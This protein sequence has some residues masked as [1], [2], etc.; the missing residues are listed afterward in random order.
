MAFNWEATET[1]WFVD[2]KYNM[3]LTQNA[4][5]DP[6]GEN[7]KGDAIGRTFISYFT[8]GDERFIQGI[9]SCWKKIERKGWFSKLLFGKYYYQ[10]YRYPHRYNHERGLSRDHLTY[11][12]LAYKLSG[13][14]NKSLKE[15]VNNLRFK[16]SDF[17]LFTPELWAWKKA[18]YGSKFYLT[19]YYLMNIPVILFNNLKNKIIYKIVPFEKEGKQENWEIIYNEQKSEK[20]KKWAKRLFP[21]FALHILA[22]QLYFLPNS[23]IKKLTQRICLGMTPKYNYVIKMLLGFKDKVNKEDIDKYKSMMGGRWTTTLNPQINNRYLILIS[24]PK[25]I[26]SNT[27]D[28]DYVKKLYNTIQC[29]S[30][31]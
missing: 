23:K 8:Y 2:Q 6:N 29:K 4:F 15:F 17:A 5:W 1:H 18:M 31:L 20:V 21:I 9:E 16:I 26:E 10:G 30:N 3:M 27:L 12:I 28:I 19:L 13:Y 7:G 11:T 14:S 25:L 24:D 22:W